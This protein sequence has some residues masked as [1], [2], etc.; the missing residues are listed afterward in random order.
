MTAGAKDWFRS[1]LRT[2]PKLVTFGRHA[3]TDMV[4]DDSPAFAA[5]RGRTVDTAA[6][7]THQEIAALAKARKISYDDALKIIAQRKP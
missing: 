3:M 7:S 1:F 5:P 4:F 2:T 6:M